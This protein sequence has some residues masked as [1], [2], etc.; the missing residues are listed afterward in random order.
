MRHGVVEIEKHKALTKV[1]KK[2]NNKKI[3]KTSNQSG[4]G[5]VTKVTA[6][7]PPGVGTSLITVTATAANVRTLVIVV[8]TTIIAVSVGV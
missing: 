1:N 5:T 2:S 6:G 3:K 4:N 8:T 7:L